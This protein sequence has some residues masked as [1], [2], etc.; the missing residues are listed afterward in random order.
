MTMQNPSPEAHLKASRDMEKKGEIGG[1]FGEAI[2]AVELV[3]PLRNFPEAARLDCY[4]QLARMCLKSN[5]RFLAE[6]VAH[7]GL[8]IGTRNALLYC[9]LAQALIAQKRSQEAKGVVDLAL[10]VDPK[11][12]VALELKKQLAEPQASSSRSWLKRG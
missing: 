6:I 12:T 2:W 1:G 9:R 4:E 7:A 11:N 5:Y 8:K 3:T 10:G